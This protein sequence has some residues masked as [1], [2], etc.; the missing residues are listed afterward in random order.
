MHVS[1]SV[2]TY[3]WVQ[4]SE[5]AQRGFGFPEL[6]LQV[7]ALQGT[8]AVHT[9][10]WTCDHWSSSPAPQSCFLLGLFWVGGHPWEK[11]L[12][13]ALSTVHSYNSLSHSLPFSFLMVNWVQPR[14]ERKTGICQCQ[15]LEYLQTDEHSAPCCCTTEKGIDAFQTHTTLGTQSGRVGMGAGIELVWLV[16]CHWWW[17]IPKV[18]RGAWE[19]KGERC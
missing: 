14:G 18:I 13:P 11:K 15:S 6:E 3:T 1:A 2:G 17:N 12:S 9:G 8:P 5:Q 16:T 7:T 10:N 4:V 19:G